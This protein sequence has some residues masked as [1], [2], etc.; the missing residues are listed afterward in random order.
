MR[1]SLMPRNAPDLPGDFVRPLTASYT[2]IRPNDYAARVG[3][4]RASVTI[5]V[6]DARA[7]RTIPIPETTFIVVCHA[8][9]V[10]LIAQS[11]PLVIHWR[12][13]DMMVLPT[14]VP[15]IRGIG[16]PVSLATRPEVSQSRPDARGRTRFGLHFE[17]SEMFFGKP[18]VVEPTTHPMPEVLTLV[19]F[20]IMRRLGGED[21]LTDGAT[22]GLPGPV[23]VA[24]RH[25][26]PTEALPAGSISLSLRAP[27][28][29]PQPARPL[30]LPDMPMPRRATPLDQPRLTSRDGSET[31]KA[32]RSDRG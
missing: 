6:A 10:A 21:L 24:V 8:A 13:S 16:F 17:K 26:P 28:S 14:E 2:R 30:G 4:H 23:E 7:D 27:L 32:Q 3:A 31:R 20:C 25:L 19:D 5:T 29:R 18:V 11:R 9:L 15:P 1:V 12:Q 22:V